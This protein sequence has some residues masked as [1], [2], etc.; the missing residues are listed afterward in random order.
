MIVDA[1]QVAWAL[2]AQAAPETGAPLLNEQSLLVLGGMVLAIVA[3]ALV[4]GTIIVLKSP[5]VLEHF[6]SAR[7]LHLITVLVIVLA[8]VVLGLERVLTGEAVASLLG[9]I[10]GYV[11]GSLKTPSE[12]GSLRQDAGADKDGNQTAR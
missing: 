9:G 8:T 2:R 7:R 5:A 4:C 10:V 6:T 11:L 1:R 12:P 3:L